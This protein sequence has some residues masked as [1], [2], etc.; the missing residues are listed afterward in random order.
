MCECVDNHWCF[1]AWKR[2]TN[3]TIVI[4]GTQNT[5]TQWTKTQSNG[6]KKSGG[7][8]HYSLARLKF[9]PTLSQHFKLLQKFDPAWSQVYICL[10]GW[11][12]MWDHF[13]KLMLAFL[14]PSMRMF[15][16]VKCSRT[17]LGPNMSDCIFWERVR[18]KYYHTHIYPENNRDSVFWKNEA[19]HFPMSNHPSP[20]QG[21]WD[22]ESQTRTL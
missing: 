13:W 20:V 11:P 17:L 16:E 5:F 14:V 4:S 2:P 7:P 8:R 12:V 22:Q 21:I 9:S 18:S 1:R 6:N 3:S 10:F 15:L 19:K